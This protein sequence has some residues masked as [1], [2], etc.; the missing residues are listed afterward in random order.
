[1][2]TSTLSWTISVQMSGEPTISTSRV[3]APMEGY[4]HV[5]VAVEADNKEKAVEVQP[6]PASRVALLLMSSSHYGTELTF[7]FS[8]GKK[9]SAGFKLTEAQVFTGA[10]LG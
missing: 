3:A 9:D 2:P 10:A 4:D 5:N 7:K 8:D 1:M 6:G